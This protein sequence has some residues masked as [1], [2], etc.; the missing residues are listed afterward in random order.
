MLRELP[1]TKYGYK[2]WQCKLCDGKFNERTG[3][4]F[5]RLQCRTEIVLLAI[6]SYIQLGLSLRDISAQLLI[7]GV[8]V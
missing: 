5:N 6:H 2:Q 1:A 8:E 3:T 4:P 7:L